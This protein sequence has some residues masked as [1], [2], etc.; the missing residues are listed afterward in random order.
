MEQ[1]LIMHPSSQDLD[2]VKCNL[3]GL[4]LVEEGG[5]LHLRGVID[6][7]IFYNP[8]TE[9]ITYNPSDNLI[10]HEYQIRDAYEIEIKFEKNTN[11]TLPQVRETGNRLNLLAKKLSI[12]LRDLHVQPNESLCLCARQDEVRKMPHGFNIETLF[13]ELIY[14]FFYSNTYFER[15]NRRPWKDLSHGILGTLEFYWRT[16]ED[17]NL[18]LIEA[19]KEAL[20]EDQSV[21][22]RVENYLVNIAKPANAKCLCGSGTKFSNCYHQEAL[23]GLLK[24][25]SE[26]AHF[27]S[28]SNDES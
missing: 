2:W 14:P 11:S 1:S 27:D 22:P 7:N 16:K 25:K 17:N 20:K 4:N 9:E 5:I 26:I 13:F 21:W 8:H 10:G 28:R 19:T 15:Y 6:F 18:P 3:P 24:L 12:D 23:S